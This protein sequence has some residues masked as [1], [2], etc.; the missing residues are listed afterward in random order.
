MLIACPPFGSHL[1]LPPNP[2]HVTIMTVRMCPS[3]SLHCCLASAYV[4]G[5][6]C[7][8]WFCFR[9]RLIHKRFRISADFPPRHLSRCFANSHGIVINPTNSASFSL[10]NV[11]YLY[12]YSGSDCSVVSSGN[13]ESAVVGVYPGSWGECDMKCGG[14]FR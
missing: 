5:R 9:I 3:S 11:S 10:L 1:P 13:D 2:I 6:C 4:S 7:S 8:D 14:G 12:R